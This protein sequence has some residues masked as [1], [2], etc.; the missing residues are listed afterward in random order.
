MNLKPLIASFL[1]VAASG[2]TISIVNDTMRGA[3]DASQSAEGLAA[4]MPSR[5]DTPARPTVRYTDTP[6]LSTRPINVKIDGIPDAHNCDI[7][8]SPTAD[9]DNFQVAQ[10]I[11]NWC[12]IPVRVSPEVTLTGSS[13]TSFS[14]PPLGELQ[15]SAANPG[16]AMGLP[17]LPAVPQG[18][19]ALGAWSG[20][21]NLSI[22]GLM[23]KGGPANGLLDM[24]T[25]RLRL[26][27][28]YSAAVNLV[29][30]YYVD[31][32][33][34]GLYAI[35]SLTDMT[36]VVSSGTTSAARV[37]NSGTCNSGSGGGISGNSGSSQST[38]VTIYTD[39]T[40]DIGNSV[41]SMLTPGVARMSMSSSTGTM[42]VTDTP[43]VL[44]RVG[45]FLNG[46][47]S[48]ITKQVLLNV[49]V[50]SVTLTDKDDLGID[51]NL[52]YT[53]VNGKSGIGWKNVTQADA[54]AV[55]GSV[56]ILVT[57]S[58]WPGSNL[59]VKAL[60][61]QGRVSTITSPS[62]TTLN[63]QPVPVQLARQTSYLA[64]IQTTITADVGS[65]TSLTPG[66]VTSGYNM[67]LLPYVMAAKE[68]LL[69]YSTNLSA[70][71]LIRQVSSADNTI[72]IPELDNRIY[73]Q[74]VELRSGET[75]VLSGF[76]QTVDNRS[77]A[78]VGSAS[79]LLMGGSLK[80]DNSKDLIVVLNTPIVEG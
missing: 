66:T 73:S 32:K 77:K 59:L 76:E 43:E 13:A 10:E 50:L 29:T 30:I 48:N 23:W 4:S 63:L 9:V 37:S 27:W 1:L 41:L 20:G 22:S 61:E 60:A 45:D 16:G 64:S 74:M 3:E 40:N 55:Q 6:W 18:A 36:T 46:V 15:G 19:S 31:T 5:Q 68:L 12:G 79:N 8:Y 39:I 51:C 28:Q 17:P 78:R 54:A 49:Q 2:C 65:T 57:S 11:T 26:S 33:T 21:R 75:S 14:L 53:A 25:V 58:Q 62:D 80:R 34:F 67:N 44:A 38:G 56:S 24:A 35:P 52:V 42:T 69:R 7:S 71:K 72:E 47:N 70:L